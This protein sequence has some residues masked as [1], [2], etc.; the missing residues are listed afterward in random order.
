VC[1]LISGESRVKIE[2]R[3]ATIPTSPRLQNITPAQPVVRRLKIEARLATIPTSP[4][5]QNITPAQPVVR[6][7][8]I[9]ARLATI[10]TSPRLQN[11]TPAQ[12]M[13]EEGC[14]QR[15]DRIYV[16]LFQ[17]FAKWTLH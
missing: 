17:V 2:A 12:P 16:P 10:P 15:T 7:L 13:V 9:E 11:I 1:F 3:L 14:P 5:L 8:K 4:R 6:R